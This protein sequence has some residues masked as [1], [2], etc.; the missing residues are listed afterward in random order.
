ML[1]GGMGGSTAV[2]HARPPIPE[3]QKKLREALDSVTQ[4]D[5]A[6]LP[7]S[8]LVQLLKQ[9]H[10]IE[11]QIGPGIDPNRTITLSAA[12][13]KLKDALLLL[14]DLYPDLCLVVRDYGLLVSTRDKGM[15]LYGAAIPADLPLMTASPAGRL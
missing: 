13:I 10:G 3:S 4:L 9:Q 2:A 1:M 5:V 15:D 11:I 8:D 7:L 12:G 14:A 6:D